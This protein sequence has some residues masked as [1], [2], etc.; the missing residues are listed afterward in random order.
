VTRYYNK[1]LGNI[2][3]GRNKN[4]IRH[5]TVSHRPL[6]V[7]ESLMSFTLPA[8]T[9]WIFPFPLL[10]RNFPCRIMT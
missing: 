4:W 10:P 1:G 7:F 6:G 9:P 3:K 8:P 2:S 5:C